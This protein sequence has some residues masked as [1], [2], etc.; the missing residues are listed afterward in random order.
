MT[1]VIAPIGKR[2]I[3]GRVWLWW[4]RCYLGEDPLLRTR[5]PFGL[6][7]LTS[8]SL[9][10]RVFRPGQANLE[11]KFEVMEAHLCQIEG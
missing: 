7:G 4:P 3:D 5:N 6:S 9:S 1:D 10:G 11:E 2:Q 8:R